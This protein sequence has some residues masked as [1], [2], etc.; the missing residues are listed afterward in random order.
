MVDLSEYREALEKAKRDFAEAEERRDRATRE[1]AEADKDLI[2][3]RRAVTA[4][5]A[6]CGEDVD[7]SIGIT[8]AI[9]TTFKGAEHGSW[10]ALDVLQRHVEEL[11][12]VLTDRKNPTASLMSVLKRLK[13]NDEIVEVV[14]QKKKYW[15]RKDGHPSEKSLMAATPVAD[16]DIPF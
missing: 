5:A 11:G 13:D 10:F 2:Q 16:D 6:L 7:E 12:V 3:L 15:K 14:N 8:A 1:A 4:L 9:R